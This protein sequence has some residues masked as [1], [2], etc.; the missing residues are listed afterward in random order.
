[1]SK[2]MT[3]LGDEVAISLG[4]SPDREIRKQQHLDK[5][6]KLLKSGG[7]FNEYSV[8]GTTFSDIANWHK[9]QAENL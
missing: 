2:N 7:F 4:F 8:R 5:A 9:F 1:M 3:L 6:D